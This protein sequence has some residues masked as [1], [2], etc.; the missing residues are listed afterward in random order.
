MKVL[1]IGSGGREHALVWKIAQSPLVEKIYC[2][3]GNP[4][5]GELAECPK[6]D[7]EGDFE[8]LAKFVK[9]EK[10]DLTV[11]GPED[12]LANGIVDYFQNSGLRFLV[13]RNRRR[14]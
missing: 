8:Q 14:R 9:D 5:I 7:I 1:V 6:M 10:I 2:I 3:P 4:G 13:P 12:P 11:V